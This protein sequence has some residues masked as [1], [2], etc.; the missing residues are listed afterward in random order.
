MRDLHADLLAAQTSGAADPYI[1][2]NINSTNYTP[3][4]V[5]LEHIEEP[6]R[7][8]AVIILANSDRHF[9]DTDLRGKSFTIGYG[10]T[11]SGSTDRYLGEGSNPA[12]PT[13][14]V[15]S[16]SMV[17]MEG[18]LV[19]ILECEGGWMMLREFI[20]TILSEPAYFNQLFKSTDSVY[21]LITKA[22]AVADFT[23]S[24]A[25][26]IYGIDGIILNFFP[27]F[28]ANP[29]T[30]ETLA[31]IIKRLIYMKIGRAHV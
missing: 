14:W 13:L 28:T 8:R 20:C 22:I 1:Y 17:S 16:Q 19:C 6:Y 24:S 25:S 15:K 31:S 7:D 30:Y 18:E 10:Y 27:Q 2:L 12:M 29:E 21:Q 5:A 3:R 23:L 11:C 4:L 9:N 26:D